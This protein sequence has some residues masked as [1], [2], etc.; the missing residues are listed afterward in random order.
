MKVPRRFDATALVHWLR[1]S[2]EH[3]HQC[4]GVARQSEALALIPVQPVRPHVARQLYRRG[5]D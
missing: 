2:I 5:D 1:N 4:L 3:L